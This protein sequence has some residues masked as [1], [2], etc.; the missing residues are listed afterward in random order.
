MLP[1]FFFPLIS[2]L[3]LSVFLVLCQTINFNL[4][5]FIAFNLPGGLYDLIDAYAQV[6]ENC[7]LQEILDL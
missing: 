3:L 5:F 6:K 1:T 4:S 2:I 7:N